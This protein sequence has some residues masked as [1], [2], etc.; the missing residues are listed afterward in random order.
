MAQGGLM[1]SPVRI[2]FVSDVACPWCAIGYRTLETAV[3]TLEMPIE[4]H[5]QP[6][7]LNPDMPAGGREVLAYLADKY[8]IS[9][10]QAEIN[11]QHIYERAA[12]VG[13]RFHPDGRKHV[14]N[15][16]DCHRLIHW[17]GEQ[18]DA[19]AAWRLKGTLLEAYF[20]RADNMDL[21]QTLLAA[22][23]RAGLSSQRAEEILQSD[24]FAHDVRAAETRF[25]MLGIQAVPAMILNN[26]FLI[27]GAQPVE[28]LQAAIVQ[29]SEHAAQTN[30]S[31]NI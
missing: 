15:T 13:F 29:A 19:Q 10:E 25:Q 17:A 5:L 23:E 27:Q 14:Y 11:Q 26:R 2:D 18:I 24:E 16:F 21:A 31:P 1:S 7:E 9:V 28:H 30:D 12:Q 3:L 6:F 22:V 20:T 8:G 4:L